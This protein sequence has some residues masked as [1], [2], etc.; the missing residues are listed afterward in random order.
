VGAGYLGNHHV[1][2]TDS[3]HRSKIEPEPSRPAYQLT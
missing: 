3:N 1:R 2:V